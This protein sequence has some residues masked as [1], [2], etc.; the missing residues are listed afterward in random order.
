MKR[1]DR[2]GFDVRIAKGT[3]ASPRRPLLPRRTPPAAPRD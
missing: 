1:L 2:L 3:G